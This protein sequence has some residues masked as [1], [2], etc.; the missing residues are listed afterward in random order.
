MK[1]DYKRQR[2]NKFWSHKGR[3]NIILKHEL[4][5]SN[6]RRHVLIPKFGTFLKWIRLRKGTDWKM[7][8]YLDHTAFKEEP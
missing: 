5:Y 3:K 8:I 7:E 2:R 1:A 4:S 6:I